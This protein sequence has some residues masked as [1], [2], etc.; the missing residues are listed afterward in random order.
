M[1]AE[2]QYMKTFFVRGGYKMNVDEE[3]FSF[4]VGFAAS[5]TPLSLSLDYGY[6]PFRNLGGIHRITMFVKL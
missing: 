6:A 4:G 1:G 3:G 2:Y 5:L